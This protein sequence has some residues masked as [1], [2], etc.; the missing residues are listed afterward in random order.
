M[1]I[2]FISQYFHPE[3]GAASERISGF[4]RNM[5]RLGH[6]ITVITGFPNYPPGK[7]YPGYR[8]K[9]FSVEKFN[10]VKVI[11][12]WLFTPNGTSVIERVLNYL[13]FMLSSVI[14]GFFVRDINYVFATSG[15]MFAGLAGYIISAVKKA[16]FIFDVRDIWPERIYAG[17]DIKRGWAIRQLE[18]LEMF[19]YRKA[20]EIIAVTNGVKANIVSKGINREKITVITN[21]VDTSVFSPRTRNQ[22]LAEKSGIKENSFVVIYAG[23][24]GL[25]QDLDLFVESAGRLKEHDDILFLMVG[26]GAKRDDFINKVEKGHLDNVKVIPPVS[27]GEL[28][29]YINLSDVGIN[30]NTN[31]PHN[32]MAIPVKIFPYMACAKPVVLANKGEI[33]ELVGVNN[34]GIC[35][36]PGDAGA[37]SEARLTFY[38]SRKL[39]RQCGENGYKL[40]RA[41][42]SMEKL[43]QKLDTLFD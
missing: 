41:G 34:I 12:V 31:H 39:L 25:L 32:D 14:A 16:P 8:K 2:L 40:V 3:I 6:R 36:A 11:R 19:L 4:A 22:A 26:G 1:H 38:R 29:D 24:L 20:A 5:A 42:Y 9:L 10:G 43:A 30:A 17:T 18:R 23:T 15:P 21:G 13:S 33:A 7:I 35:V 27:A 37:F 28:C